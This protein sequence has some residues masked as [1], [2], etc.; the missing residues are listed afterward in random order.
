MS[1]AGAGMKKAD[2]VK[3]RANIV[4]DRRLQSMVPPSSAPRGGGPGQLT[5][6]PW[7]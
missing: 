6:T 2:I 3:T 1:E 4:T 5:I 7:R